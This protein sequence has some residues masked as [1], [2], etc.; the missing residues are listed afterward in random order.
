[1]LKKLLPNWKQL[2]ICT[3][4]NQIIFACMRI[5]VI[6]HSRSGDYAEYVYSLIDERAK[7]NN[8]LL[9]TWSNSVPAFQQQIEDDSIIYINIESNSSFILNWLYNVKIPSILK[10]TRAEIVI[11]LNGVAS[12]Q[13]KIPQ[14][15]IANQFL[16]KKDKRELNGIEKFALKNLQQSIK[17]AKNV[18]CY[19]NNKFDSIDFFKKDE[20]QFIPFAA[21]DIF[22]VY[23]WHDKLMVKANHADNKEYFLAVLDEND[24][25]TF[26]LLLQAFTK[27]KKW[28]Q[29]NMQLLI[30][31]KYETLGAEIFQK[32]KTYKYRDDVRLLE[33]IGEKQVAAIFA[34]ASAFIHANTEK[35]NLLMIVTA[36]KCG[37]PVITFLND[38]IKE[39]T[40]N[41]A[42]YYTE[43]NF[44][45]IG[46]AIIKLYKDENLQSQLK[47]EAQKQS[48]TLNRS[49]CINKLWQL[50]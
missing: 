2:F 43:N 50:F 22:R 47:E 19:S 8:Y 16:L 23:E 6:E 18:L 14:L 32:H 42:L 7:Q 17:L 35:P 41:A 38:D 27:F 3:M 45:T 9:K 40:A 1:M 39:Y 34:S 4:Y 36:L 13:I 21:P 11:D 26:V 30:L 29:S 10:K 44:E 37:L 49:E 12:N 46:N 28:Q 33:E 24:I 25:D 5:A 48:E 20:L 15:I 31:P